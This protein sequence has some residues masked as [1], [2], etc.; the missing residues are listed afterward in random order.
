MKNF[1]FLLLFSFVLTLQAQRADFKEIN[2]AKAEY[3]ADRYQGEAL[4]NV[5]ELVYG[6][7]SQLETDAM[8]FRA[9]YYWVTHNISG[10]YDLM[11]K[12]V[13]SR[14]KLKNDP[15]G[16]YQWNDQFKK[17]VF[18]TLLQDKETICTGYAYLIKVMCSLAGIECEIIDGYAANDLKIKNLDLPNHS[19][20]AIKLNDTWY[21]CDATWSAGYTD[22][23]T[24][25]FEFDYDNSYFLQEP[26]AFIKSHQPLDKKWTL[27]PEN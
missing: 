2:F 3:T 5:P 20:N 16:V 18:T 27:L 25:L 13:R 19:W 9:I 12:N 7:T 23:S 17:E 4:T 26:D 6:L 14:K 21:L 22:M 8:R 10:N 24:Y 11:A 1:I 15:E